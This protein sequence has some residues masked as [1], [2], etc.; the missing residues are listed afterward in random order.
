MQK[1]RKKKM[2]EIKN[3][4]LIVVVAILAVTGLEI[5]ALYKGFNGT[6]LSVSLAIIAGLAGLSLPQLKLIKD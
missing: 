5:A 2:S 1:K 3:N 6:I 4:T